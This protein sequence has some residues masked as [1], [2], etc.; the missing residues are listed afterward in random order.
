MHYP[1]KENYYCSRVNVNV[2]AS[3][4]S[5]CLYVVSLGPR[6]VVRVLRVEFNASTNVLN[7]SQMIP[8]Y[9]LQVDGLYKQ[10]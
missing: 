3:H 6:M 4:H 10:F 2:L 9:E 7:Y 8:N 1:T 5:V